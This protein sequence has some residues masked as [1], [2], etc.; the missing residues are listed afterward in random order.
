MTTSSHDYII[1]KSMGLVRRMNFLILGM[2][3]LSS[4]VSESTNDEGATESAYIVCAYAW[5]A[6]ENPL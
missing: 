2:K 1:K 4:L 3:V 6:G 5:V